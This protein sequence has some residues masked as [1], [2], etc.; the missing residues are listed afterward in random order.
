MACAFWS[1]D[2]AVLRVLL[3]RGR[4][5]VEF[6]PQ[7]GEVVGVGR[8]GSQVVLFPGVWPQIEWVFYSVLVQ[9]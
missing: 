5:G 7:P 2:K 9:C 4:Q 8:V 3:A 6:G 1:G